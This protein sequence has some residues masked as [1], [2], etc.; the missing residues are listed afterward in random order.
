MN[1]AHEY[2][3]LLTSRTAAKWHLSG[4]VTP[5]GQLQNE[6]GK[7]PEP[8]SDGDEQERTRGIEGRVDCLHCNIPRFVRK[9]PQER[10]SVWHY[11]YWKRK[12]HAELCR[13]E[14]QDGRGQFAQEVL[15][16]WPSLSSLVFVVV[17]SCI[18][19]L[20]IV[21]F[22]KFQLL[23]HWEDWTRFHCQC[24]YEHHNVHFGYYIILYF[25][26]FI[27]SGRSKCISRSQLVWNWNVV[28]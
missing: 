5:P 25:L 2:T 15:G 3:T 9:N 22:T 18:G 14:G 7:N 24:K 10:G 16:P 19:T 26:D 8:C 23:S 1:F 27:E 11:T 20:W 6:G 4:Q 28:V 13:F 21:F 17:L 12:N